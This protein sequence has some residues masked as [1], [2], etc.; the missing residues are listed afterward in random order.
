M[1]DKL[2]AAIEALL[3]QLQQQQQ[4]VIETKRTIN[5]LCKRIGEELLFPDAMTETS[6]I[7]MAPIRADQFYG[8]PLATAA[9]EFLERRRQACTADEILKGLT[10]GGFDFR[11]MGWKDDDRLRSLAISLAKNSKAFHKLPN[12]TFGLPAWYPDAVKRQERE[13]ESAANGKAQETMKQIDEMNEIKKPYS[14]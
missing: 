8:K 7:T 14:L 12:N 1:K 3:E 10:E 2:S 5:V 11:P 6:D 13:R 9:Q 4:E